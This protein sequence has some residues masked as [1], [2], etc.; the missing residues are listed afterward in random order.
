MVHPQ[1]QAEKMPDWRAQSPGRGTDRK[2][3]QPASGKRRGDG[4][5]GTGVS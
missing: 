1:S 4:G 3:K 5:E 2:E